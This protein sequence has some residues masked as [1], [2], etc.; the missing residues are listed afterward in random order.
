MAAFADFVVDLELAVLIDRM[1]SLAGDLEFFGMLLVR[2]IL[3]RIVDRLREFRLAVTEGQA[4]VFFTN[5]GARVRRFVRWA[6]VGHR[7]LHFVR[8]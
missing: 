1:A 7:G 3:A 5:G 2:K 8:G 6:D 4:A